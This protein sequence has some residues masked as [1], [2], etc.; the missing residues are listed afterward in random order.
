MG[1]KAGK[2]SRANSFRELRARVMTGLIGALLLFL[3]VGFGELAGL[4]LV[5]WL[6]ASGMVLEYVRMGISPRYQAACKLWLLVLCPIVLTLSVFMPAWQLGLVYATFVGTAIFF[7]TLARS[8]TADLR[9]LVR[10]WSATSF[11]LIYLLW[12]PSLALQI[13]QFPHGILWLVTTLSLVWAGDIGAYFVGIGYGATPLHAQVSPKKT[14]EGSLGGILAVLSVMV[15]LL[16]WLGGE[17]EVHAGAQ[18]T[19]EWTPLKVWFVGLGFAFLVAL[20]TQLGDLAESL[21]KRAHQVKD[22]S[23]ILP[24]HGGFLDR[25]DGFLFALPAMYGLLLV[26]YN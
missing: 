20:L 21:L 19:R 23:H 26:I 5:V 1:K 13:Y 14:W 12:L 4:F 10:D 25:F 24:G 9:L 6:I 22:T 17:L 11:A 18:G 7:L 15:G 2:P 8:Q 3:L 16:V